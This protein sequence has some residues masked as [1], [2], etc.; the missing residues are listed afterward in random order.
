MGPLPQG[1]TSRSCWAVQASVGDEGDRSVKNP[2]GMQ[3]NN[4]EDVGGAEEE[5]MD[6]GEVTGPDLSG[7]IL[8]KSRPGLVRF[9]PFL[10]H[11]P[12][13]G[14]FADFECQV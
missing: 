14:A 7:V 4:N 1:V 8:E 3:L 13:D 5:I 10:G 12:L 9:F 6:D 11:I 2:A